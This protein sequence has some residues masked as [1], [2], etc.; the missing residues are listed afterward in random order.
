MMMLLLLLLLVVVHSE[1]RPT[2]NLG[3]FFRPLGVASSDLQ[4]Q[5]A[6]LHGTDTKDEGVIGPK[7]TY[8]TVGTKNFRLFFNLP[9]NW[10]IFTKDKV[11]KLNTIN[12][13]QH[14]NYAFKVVSAICYL[15]M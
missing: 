14:S 1:R 6:S 3:H 12:L 11:V 10:D 9:C 13:C 5:F 8:R 15:S 2:D 4:Y 7:K